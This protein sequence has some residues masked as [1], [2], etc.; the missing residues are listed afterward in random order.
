VLLPGT[1]SLLP[2]LKIAPDVSTDAPACLG[3]LVAGTTSLS[4]TP[5]PS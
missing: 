1:F 2:H 3:L 4:P 5:F